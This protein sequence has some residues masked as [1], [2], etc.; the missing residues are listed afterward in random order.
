[1]N[2]WIQQLARRVLHDMKGL[3]NNC[4]YFIIVNSIWIT[5]SYILI[6][7]DSLVV[8]YGKKSRSLDNM[9][10]TLGNHKQPLSGL[11][12]SLD[13]KVVESSK[14]HLNNYKELKIDILFIIFIIIEKSSCRDTYKNSKNNLFLRCQK[15]QPKLNLNFLKRSLLFWRYPFI[16]IPMNYLPRGG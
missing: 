13:S 10:D 8:N 2:F 5:A 14:L 12:T 16:L 4:N 15:L 6:E 3:K 1:M 11:R 7:N 9:Q